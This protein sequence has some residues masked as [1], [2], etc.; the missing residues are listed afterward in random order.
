MDVTG[1]R[2]DYIVKLWAPTSATASRA[3]SAVGVLFV[4]VFVLS[5]PISAAISA[6]NPVK[7][8]VY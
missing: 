6:W 3:I 7:R 8:I 4:L 1:L 5:V 2:L